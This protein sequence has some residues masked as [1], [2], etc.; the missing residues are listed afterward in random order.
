MEIVLERA[1]SAQNSK[2]R[3]VSLHGHEFQSFYFNQVIDPNNVKIKNG[4]N[5]DSCETERRRDGT[6]IPTS[7]VIVIERIKNGSISLTSDYAP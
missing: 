2:I 7:S 5:G 3:K 1:K 4:F 6:K